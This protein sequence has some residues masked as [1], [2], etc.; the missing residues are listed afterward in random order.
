[1][2]LRVVRRK[3]YRLLGV[4]DLTFQIVF[5]QSGTREQT[6]MIGWS[7]CHRASNELFTFLAIYEPG[8]ARQRVNTILAQLKRVSVGS[9][10]ALRIAVSCGYISFKYRAAT[11]RRCSACA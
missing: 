8:Q 3:A 9:A 7:C 6:A 2:R 11:P 10:R 1:M 5:A 4:G